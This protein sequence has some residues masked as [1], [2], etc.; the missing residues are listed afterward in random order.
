[1]RAVTPKELSFLGGFLP[2]TYLPFTPKPDEP[3]I[4]FS[5]LRTKFAVAEEIATVLGKAV[6]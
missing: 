3:S 6:S 4:D 1:M 2:A 5:K